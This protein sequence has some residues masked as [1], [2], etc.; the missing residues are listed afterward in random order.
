MDINFEQLKRLLQTFFFQVLKS[1]Q[2][3]TIT[4][5]VRLSSFP[6]YLVLTYLR[7]VRRIRFSCPKIG[8]SAEITEILTVCAFDCM[9]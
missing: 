7:V 1:R 9:N 8:F 5:N 6:T 3:A 2:T 4:V